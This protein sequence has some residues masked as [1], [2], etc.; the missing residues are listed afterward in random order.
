LDLIFHLSNL[1]WQDCESIVSCVLFDANLFFQRISLHYR[2]R[3]FLY[4][5]G[6]FG[7]GELFVSCAN[8]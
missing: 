8:C 2:F 3:R 1:G 5:A 4:V 7:F 6:N